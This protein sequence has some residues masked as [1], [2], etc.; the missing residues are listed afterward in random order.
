[1]VKGQ[2]SYITTEGTSTKSFDLK[3]LY[4]GCVLA[5]QTG[6]VAQGCTIQYTG[7]RTDGVV[8]SKTC[9]F[10]TLATQLAFCE[11]PTGFK[12]LKS[13]KIVPVRADLLPPT[14][15]VF[16]DTVLGSTYT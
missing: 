14:T 10:N 7:V 1:M 5:S 13:V 15:V 4:N 16:I 9:V 3:S 2:A 6:V 11:F 8:V 12:G